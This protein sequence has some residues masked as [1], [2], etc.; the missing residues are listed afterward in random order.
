MAEDRERLFL[1]ALDAFDSARTVEDFE[2]SALLFESILSDGYENGAVLYNLGNAYMRA[3]K[4]GK[5]IAA[6]R[7]A[8]RFRPRDPYLAANLKVAL[9]EAPGTLG[10]AD[11]PWWHRVLFWHASLSQSERQWIGASA[12]G[13]AFLLALVR[14]WIGP[15]AR[16]LPGLRWA[17][18]A[19]LAFGILLSI[20]AGLGYRDDVLTRKGVVLSETQARKGNGDDYAPS[21]DRPVKEGAE[22]VVIESRAGWVHVRLSGVGEGWLPEN[23]VAVY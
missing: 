6:Y 21:F 16:R 14:L 3:G 7:R 12:W 5:A 9:G 23:Q 4:V 8:H 22:F 10:E 1:R 2:R 18:Y 13:L 20:S 15:G 11:V 19:A 17:M